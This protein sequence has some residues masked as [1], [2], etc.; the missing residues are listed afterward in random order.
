MAYNFDITL[1]IQQE[2]FRFQVSEDDSHRV[3][4]IKGLT[5]TTSTKPGCRLIKIIPGGCEKI[6][7]LMK[8]DIP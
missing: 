1:S 2:V 7:K 4:V 3:K 5:D 8:Q 6:D